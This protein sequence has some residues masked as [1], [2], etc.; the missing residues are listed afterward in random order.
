MYLNLQKKWLINFI[1]L[2]LILRSLLPGFV[3]YR[4]AY[5]LTHV[6]LV[7]A[8]L[9]IVV[10]YYRAVFN[11]RIIPVLALFIVYCHNN[12]YWSGGRINFYIYGITLLVCVFA[13]S[14]EGDWINFYLKGAT[15]FGLIHAFA[16]IILRFLPGV[17]L[18]VV[19]PLYPTTYSRLV[20]WYADG[21]MPGLAGHYSTNGMFL[22]VGLYASVGLALMSKTKELYKRFLPSFI[23]MIAIMLTGKRSHLF[24]SIIVLYALYYFYLS[25]DKRTRSMRMIAMALI[26]LFVGFIIILYVPSLGNA[27]ARFK[28]SADNG[29]ITNNR[30]YFWGL[31]IQLFIQKPVLGVGWGQFQE[32]CEQYLSYRAHAHNTFFQLLCETGVLGFAVYVLWM[33]VFLIISIRMFINIRTKLDDQNRLG[34]MAFSVQMQIFFILYCF[35]GNPLYEKE[36]FIPYFIAC[37]IA[38]YEDYLTRKN[39]VIN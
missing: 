16:T 13:L 17:Y 26:A 10:Y 9:T 4:F 28:E 25:N 29:D 30:I 23:I 36:M 3:P 7:V 21:C 14:G 27:F 38:L 34:M 35:T 1:V 19:A 24:F 20:N 22:V 8:V 31:A 12:Y 5:T 6:T 39:K 15:I 33:V 2:A 11:W 18:G 32:Y 37:A